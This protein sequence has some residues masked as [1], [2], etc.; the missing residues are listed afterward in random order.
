MP[1]LSGQL[2]GQ[3]LL[4]IGIADVLGWT[5]PGHGQRLW[6]PASGW[7]PVAASGR[8]ASMPSLGPPPDVFAPTPHVCITAGLCDSDRTLRHVV[9]LRQHP[10]REAAAPSSARYRRVQV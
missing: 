1:Q 5:R 9:A 4:T 7:Y 3:T 2:S 10:T 6:G 8:L